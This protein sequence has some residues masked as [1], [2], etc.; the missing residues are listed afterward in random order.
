MQEILNIA[1]YKFVAIHDSPELREDLRARTQA[2]GLMGTILLAPEGI[3][4]F[5]A[6]T[7]DA[8]HTFLADLRA[9]ARFA[10]L[11]TKESW[12]ETQPFR[13]ML[14]KLKR[15]IIRMDH[16]AIQP[17]AGR[18]PG[19]DALTLKRWLDQGHDDE[20]REI[21]LLDTRN[22]FEVDEGT[23]DGAIDWRITKF[24][25]FPPALKAHRA[26]FEGKTVVS[27][28]TGGIRCEKAAILMREEGVEHVLQLE[29][30]ILKY[31]EEVGGA[32]YHGDCFVFDGRRA[33]APDL[34]ARAADASARASEDIDLGRGLKK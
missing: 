23:F 4:L 31:F 25:E 13:R 2:L 28:C 7:A 22:D 20:G 8:I 26:E 17:A 34:S 14:V 5:L 18:A 15:E 24:T 33:L 10:D 27:F 19:V 29:G 11:E 30:G 21:A 32:H 9:D 1:A 12:S 6:G 3:N 16:P